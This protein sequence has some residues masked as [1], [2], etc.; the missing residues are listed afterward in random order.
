MS[1]LSLRPLV[2]T[3]SQSTLNF[4]VGAPGDISVP[5]FETVVWA[6]ASDHT[7]TYGNSQSGYWQWWFNLLPAFSF[8]GCATFFAGLGGTVQSGSVQ[9]DLELLDAATTVLTRASML[10]SYTVDL[11]TIPGFTYS[12]SASLPTVGVEKIDTFNAVRVRSTCSNTNLSQVLNYGP[13]GGGPA[14]SASVSY[15][16]PHILVDRYN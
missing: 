4:S 7:Q 15:V 14:T 16:A 2:I 12:V 10:V 5:I 9:L 8:P 6:N 3:S 1:N 11:T 13:L